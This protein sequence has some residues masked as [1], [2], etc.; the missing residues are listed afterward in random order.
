[1]ASID[2]PSSQLCLAEQD[3]EPYYIEDEGNSATTDT[4]TDYDEGSGSGSG[5]GS[6]NSFDGSDA[7]DYFIET[8]CV[9]I[10][11]YY[12]YWY[13]YWYE[14]N[15]LYQQ[16][17]HTVAKRNVNSS[18][19]NDTRNDTNS[20]IANDSDNDISNDNDDSSDEFFVQLFGL[21]GECAQV[22]KLD[23]SE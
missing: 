23:E 22:L 18:D 4:N 11:E 16:Q 1:M 13:Y 3:I 12:T 2:I 20:S 17:I 8:P 9:Y 19:Y 10:N 21:F 7:I 6:V 15:E 14:P 5:L